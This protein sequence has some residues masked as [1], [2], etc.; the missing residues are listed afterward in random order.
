CSYVPAVSG[1]HE[2]YLMFL[3]PY[4]LMFTALAA[5]K[6]RYGVYTLAQQPQRAE[7][8]IFHTEQ[9]KIR[10]PATENPPAH[11]ILR[12]LIL[13]LQRTWYGLDKALCQM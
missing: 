2:R 4:V 12:H 1:K 6:T 7:R 11:N 8:A 10:T 5:A 9:Q 3:C 13:T